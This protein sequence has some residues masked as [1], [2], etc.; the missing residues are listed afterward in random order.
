MLLWHV[1][2]LGYV[3]LQTK[4]KYIDDTINAHTADKP[5]V[6]EERIIVFR[7]SFWKNQFELR[8]ANTC[9][10]ISRTLSMDC[11]VNFKAP[12]FDM[13]RSGDIRGLRDAFY[14][15][16]VSLNVVNPLGMGLLHVSV[17]TR[18]HSHH[19]NVDSMQ[20]VASKKKCVLGFS[21][22]VWVLIV[23]VWWESV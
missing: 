14:S 15:G 9:G 5:F 20:R 21:K 19:L 7:P 11:V 22:L 2:K 18:T 3:S 23:Q 16:S 6:S 13:C 8:L 12:V 4:S 1:G 10:R 17:V